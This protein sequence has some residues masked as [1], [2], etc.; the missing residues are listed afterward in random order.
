MLPEELSVILE[1]SC[2]WSPKAGGYKSHVVVEHLKYGVS[3][4]LYFLTSLF[5]KKNIFINFMYMVCY[6][7][8]HQKK[9]HQIP[10]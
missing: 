9:G 1:M 4:K 10:I 7:C 5:F 3:E 6:L 8:A 2:V